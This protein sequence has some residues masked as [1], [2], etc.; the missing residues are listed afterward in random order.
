[1]PQHYDCF[2]GGP[3]GPPGLLAGEAGIS[4]LYH[5]RPFMVF[6]PKWEAG[7]RRAMGLQPARISLCCRPRQSISCRAGC[8][9]I[10]LPTAQTW[11]TSLARCTSPRLWARSCPLGSWRRRRWC[12]RGS[13]PC[14]GPACPGIVPASREVTSLGRAI[15]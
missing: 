2:T 7:R 8:V 9:R 5:R 6:V 11:T 3:A 10:S 1:L 12:C 14:T 4:P 13:P 15:L